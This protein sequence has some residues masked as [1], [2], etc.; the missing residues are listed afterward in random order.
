MRES[1]IQAD[2]GNTSGKIENEIEG[3]LNF[4]LQ[5][6]GLNKNKKMDLLAEKEQN[7]LL[8]CNSKKI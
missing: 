6:L 4:N 8:N 3:A 5:I 1:L 2:G 7:F